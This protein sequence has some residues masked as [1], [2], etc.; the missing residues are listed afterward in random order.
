MI[1]PLPGATPTKPGSATLPFFGVEPI[2]VDDQGHVLEGDGVSGNLCLG[3]PWPGQARTLYG[4]HRRFRDTY[5]SQ[6]PPLYFTGDGCRRDEDGYYWITGRVD[7][8]LNVSG[9]RLGTAEIESALVSHEAVAEAAVVGF[10]HDIKGTGI[11]AF[12]DLIPEHRGNDRE[13]LIGALKE[14]VRHEIGPIARP[15]RIQIAAGLPKT[16]SGKIMR[17]ILRKIAAG[18]FADLGDVTTLADPSV[19]EALVE[20]RRRSA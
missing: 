18:D 17:R 9:H 16:R 1:T 15:D 12:V 13:E 3:R 20:E 19:V 11:Y 10:P 2:L 6:F 4:D 7:D 5:F 8:V 14:H